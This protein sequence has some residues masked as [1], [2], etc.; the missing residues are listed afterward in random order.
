MLLQLVL[1]SPPPEESQ[2]A[3]AQLPE[4]G[5]QQPLPVLQAVLLQEPAHRELASGL[6][7]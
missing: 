1:V 6:V 4:E 5:D 3:V 7:R 2:R